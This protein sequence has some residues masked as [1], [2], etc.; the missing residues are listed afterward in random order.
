MRF[1]Y[2][3][4]QVPASFV[5]CRLL[6]ISNMS[7]I[8]FS[9]LYFAVSDKLGKYAMECSDFSINQLLFLSLKDNELANT[10]NAEN[11][12]RKNWLKI[13]FNNLLPVDINLRALFTTHDISVYCVFQTLDQTCDNV[14]YLTN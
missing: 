7:A 6:C 13:V 12:A 1:I 10:K 2:A 11:S 5:K 3:T 9:W 4:Q 14:L 8:R